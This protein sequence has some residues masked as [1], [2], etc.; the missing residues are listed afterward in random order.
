MAPDGTKFGART[1]HSGRWD[2]RGTRPG[3]S[4]RHKCVRLASAARRRVLAA[5]FGVSF[6]TVSP[7]KFAQE[8]R[9]VAGSPFFGILT[10]VPGAVLYVT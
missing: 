4:A 6:I 8:A 3:R 9:V 1:A 5:H 7:S 10:T 2:G